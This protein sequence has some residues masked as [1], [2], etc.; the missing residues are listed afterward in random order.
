[1][2]F[3]LTLGKKK[4]FEDELRYLKTEGRQGAVLKIQEARAFGDLSENAEYDIAK[5]EQGKLEARILELEEI[6]HNCEVIEIKTGGDTVEIGSMVEIADTAAGVSKQIVIVGVYE[7][8]P[9]AE[10]KRISNESPLGKTLLG[11]KAG[12]SVIF[13]HGGKKV[14]YKINKIS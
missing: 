10:P 7:S 4:E 14:T 3:Q 6:L 8:D 1:M 9:L 2:A 12:E 11:H 13:E 5:A